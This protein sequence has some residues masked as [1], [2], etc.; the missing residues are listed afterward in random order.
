MYLKLSINN[1]LLISSSVIFIFRRKDF[2][3]KWPFTF[4]NTSLLSQMLVSLNFYFIRESIGIREMEVQ[5]ATLDQ[6][7][8]SKKKPNKRHNKKRDSDLGSYEWRR[9]RSHS[10]DWTRVEWLEYETLMCEKG[11]PALPTPVI[12]S[13]HAL[14]EGRR[15]P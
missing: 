9:H 10:F 2:F 15:N 1:F 7:A 4:E 3:L 12:G 5:E 8:H 6:L 11:L 14:E 13:L